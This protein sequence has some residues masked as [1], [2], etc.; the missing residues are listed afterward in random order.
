MSELLSDK[1]L[2]EL[3]PAENLKFRSPVPV[4]SISNGEIMVGPQTDS[5]RQVESRI[6]DLAEEFSQREGVSR[7]HFL[8]TAAG[9]A[10]GFLAMN[11]I[12]G[13]LFVVSRAEAATRKISRTQKSNC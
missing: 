5:Q 4:R 6:R 11:D 1:D 12:Y 13:D 9:M 2:A 3:A 8:R 10:V 7:R